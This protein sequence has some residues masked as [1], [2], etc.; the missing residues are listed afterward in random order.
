[1]ADSRDDMGARLAGAARFIGLGGWLVAAAGVPLALVLGSGPLLLLAAL[2]SLLWLL[3][4]LVLPALF[5]RRNAPER[6][7]LRLHF[8]QWGGV[9]SAATASFCLLA[10]QWHV[11]LFSLTAAFLVAGLLCS[12]VLAVLSLW[13]LRTRSRHPERIFAGQPFPVEVSLRNRKRFLGAFAL[14]VDGPGHNGAPASSG[15]T[16]VRLPGGAEASFTLRQVL[17]ERGNHLLPPVTVSSGFP[18]GLV[19]ASLSAQSH[20]EVLVLPRL[21]RIESTAFVRLKGGAAKWL[22]Q[23]RVRDQQGEFRSLREYRPGDDPRHIHWATSARLRKLHVREFERRYV[24]SVLILLDASVPDGQGESD[25]GR[26]ARL[27]K[28]VSF[29][30]TL[31]ALLTRRNVFFAFASYCPD[32]TTLPYD[33]GRGHT[34]A[35]LEA[36][37][38]GRPARDRTLRDLFRAID[39]REARG[40]CCVVT[41]GPCDASGL[42][43]YLEPSTALVDASEPEFNEYFSLDD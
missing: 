3:V 37:A 22:E 38:L 16:L 41:P 11:N 36:L 9:Y 30:G 40:G 13:R 32:L 33:C 24:Q 20:E 7:R 31:G 34:F 18:F 2:V 27:E 15:H 39:P 29:A 12:P 10:L 28:A 23:L 26:L 21:G 17:P 43:G 1:M 5:V 6:T 19:D 42:P 25:P 35:L 4:S 8:T 14:R